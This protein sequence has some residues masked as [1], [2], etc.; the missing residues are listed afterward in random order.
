MMCHDRIRMIS[1]HHDQSAFLQYRCYYPADTEPECYSEYRYYC[2]RKY[3]S[4]V[5]PYRPCKGVIYR[6]FIFCDD[7]KLQS[8]Y[9]PKVCQVIKLIMFFPFIFVDYSKLIKWK[10]ILRDYF[11][12]W[13]QMSMRIGYARVSTVEQHEERQMIE[14]KEKAVALRS[15]S[16]TRMTF[17]N[18]DK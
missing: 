18:Q 5:E 1:D 13:R 6:S 12:V 4:L 2:R 9:Y 8:K 3:R 15:L 16:Q 7:H 17:E 11:I 14:L 10:Q